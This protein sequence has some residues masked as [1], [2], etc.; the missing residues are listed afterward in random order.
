VHRD[1][2]GTEY[3]SIAVL[4]DLLVSGVKLDLS[5]VR[6]L[7]SGKSQAKALTQVRRVLVNGM[8]LTGIAEGIETAVQAAPLCD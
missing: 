4:R 5:F 3:S 8:H 2:F 6:D 1:D 7:V